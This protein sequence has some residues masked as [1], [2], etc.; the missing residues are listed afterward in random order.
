MENSFLNA[1]GLARALLASSVVGQQMV[2]VFILAGQSNM[3]VGTD[4]M[5]LKDG[6]DI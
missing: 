4:P 5:A 2:R 1:V 3:G 6:N